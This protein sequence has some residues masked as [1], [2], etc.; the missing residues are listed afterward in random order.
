MHT[1]HHRVQNTAKVNQLK[2][3][4]TTTEALAITTPAAEATATTTALT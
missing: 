1:G 4:T 3:T 2:I